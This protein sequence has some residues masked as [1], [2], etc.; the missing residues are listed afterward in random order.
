MKVVLN[1][2]CPG[3]FQLSGEALKWLQ[4][5]GSELV[6]YGDPSAGLEEGDICGMGLSDLFPGRIDPDL[7]AVVE[8]LGPRASHRLWSH[9]QVFEVPDDINWCIR[10]HHGFEYVAEY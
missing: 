9:L 5:R 3:G 1:R 8:A 7:V 2:C 6:K 10:G 4:Q